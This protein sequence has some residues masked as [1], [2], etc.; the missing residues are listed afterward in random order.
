MSDDD[1][2]SVQKPYWE[3]DDVQAIKGSVSRFREG[4]KARRN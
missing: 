2:A 1:A 4:R 3:S